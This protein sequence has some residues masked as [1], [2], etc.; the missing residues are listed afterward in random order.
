[1]SL[2]YALFADQRSGETLGKCREFEADVEK[3]IALL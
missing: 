2:P 1:L 3:F